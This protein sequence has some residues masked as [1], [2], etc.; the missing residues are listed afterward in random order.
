MKTIIPAA[1]FAILILS[2]SF[3]ESTAGS[4][5]PDLVIIKIERPQWVQEVHGSRITVVVANR[6]LDCGAFSVSLEDYDPVKREDL[7]NDLSRYEREVLED[8]LA[9]ETM[10]PLK[11]DTY[12]KLKKRI[13]KLGMGEVKR[14]T[15]TLKNHWVFDA[16]CELKA[17]ADSGNLV[18]ESD[19]G[20]NCKLFVSRG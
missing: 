20:N 15:F 16:D 19:E 7:W 2:G 18:D 11:S 1:L 13:S 6:G 14:L 3:A 4:R 5:K 10:K 8:H 17:C 9:N 12:F